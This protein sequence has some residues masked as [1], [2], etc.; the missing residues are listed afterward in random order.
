MG[1]DYGVDWSSLRTRGGVGTDPG[2]IRALLHAPRHLDR[3]SLHRPL[4]RA[5]DGPKAPA[6]PARQSAAGQLQHR[7]RES[8]TRAPPAAA[9]R[10]AVTALD[11]GKPEDYSRLRPYR[12]V[13]CRNLR[14]RTDPTPLPS[15]CT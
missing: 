5:G 15:L 12:G 11:P 6:P 9:R 14:I 3:S 1:G 13:V 2:L 10:R 4:P 7:I 8:R